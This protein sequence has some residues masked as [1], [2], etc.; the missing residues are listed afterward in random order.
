[1]TVLTSQNDRWSLDF[2]SDQLMDG[3]RLHP[4]VSGAGGR[5]LALGHPGGAGTGPAGDRT[6]QA[7]NGGQ[8][9]GVAGGN[10]AVLLSS[11]A[12]ASRF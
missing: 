4:R 10:S 7:D 3:R 8:R 12:A 11:R 5:H 2:I 1:M 6:R 9:C